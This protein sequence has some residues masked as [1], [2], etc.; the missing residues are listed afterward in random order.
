M[1]A[2]ICPACER[3]MGDG[4]QCQHCGT[5]PEKYLAARKAAGDAALQAVRLEPEKRKTRNG[6]IVFGVL[7]VVIVTSLAMTPK[8]DTVTDRHA[9]AE[10]E[11]LV[12]RQLRVPDSANF[13]GLTE[14]SAAKLEAGLW[15]IRGHVTSKNAFGVDLRSEYVCSVR[16]LGDRRW[17]DE[18][19]VVLPR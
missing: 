2:K 16:Y 13:S 6:L 5:Y 15:A 19:V 11:R 9:K 1:A 4:D 18:G 17:K 3:L 10:C 7:A 14:T 12:K 8:S